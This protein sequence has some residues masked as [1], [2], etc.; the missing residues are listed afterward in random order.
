MNAATLLAAMAPCAQLLGERVALEPLEHHVG[1]QRAGRGGHRGAGGDG[2]RDVQRALREA[3]VDLALVAEATDERLDQRRPELRLELQ[4]LDGHRLVEPDVLAAVD[5]AEPT[6]ADD[7]QSRGTVRRAPVLPGRKTSC[8]ATDATIH[9][10]GGWATRPLGGD[11]LS[12]R[13]LAFCEHPCHDPI[14]AMKE[15][16]PDLAERATAARERGR[17]RGERSARA[18]QRARSRRVVA[19][20][21]ASRP[22]RSRASWSSH[23]D[24][25][26]TEIRRAQRVI[27]AVLGL[28]RGEAVTLEPPTSRRSSTARGAPW[29][30]RPT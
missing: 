14:W 9:R 5:D 29:C 30:C 4:A 13:P 8:V 2:A 28:A 23:L 24:K 11:L 26:T 19:L 21:R 15:D 3:V 25:V 27:G 17:G 10:L 18:A 6:L 7:G 1:H 22:R 16:P 12:G 20:S